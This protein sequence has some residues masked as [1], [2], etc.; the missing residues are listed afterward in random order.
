[1][2]PLAEIPSCWT[3]LSKRPITIY[4]AEVPKDTCLWAEEPATFVPEYEGVGRPPTRPRLAPDAPAPLTVAE[5]AHNCLKMLGRCMPSK[6]APR[7]S[8][9]PKLPFVAWSR[10]EM[11]CLA[12][13]VWLILRRSTSNP[14]D[15]HA[16]LC[17]APE[18]MVHEAMIRVCAL[19]W[20]IETMFEQAKQLVG[21]NEYETRTWFG[22]HHHMTLVILAFGFLA[23]CQLCLKLDAPA[24]T[25]PQVV[26]LLKAVL[27]KPDFDA[28][29]CH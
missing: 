19:R 8:S 18:D 9:L 10:F 13:A 7:A 23:R 14:H 6:K 1:M 2:R 26:D 25:V 21:L 20:P 11:G 4:L 22:W 16:F 15:Y 12:H 28:P 27:P 24:L 3:G 17:N 5:I 29:G